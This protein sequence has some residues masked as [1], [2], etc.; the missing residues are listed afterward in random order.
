MIGISATIPLHM[1]LSAVLFDLDGTL[2]DSTRLFCD[3]VI[4]GMSSIGVSHMDMQIFNEWHGNHEHWE[5]LITRHKG[6]PSHWQT[7]ERV[8]FEKFDELLTTGSEWMEGAEMTVRSLAKRGMPMAIVT[9]SLDQFIDTIDR[10]IPLKSLFPIIITASRTQERRK[11]D[12][13]G[14][15]L[16]AEQLGVSPSDCMYVGDQ[17]FDIVAAQGA[18]MH[19]CLF[20]GPHTPPDVEL[21]AKHRVKSL[22][23]I[24]QL[25]D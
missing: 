4:H 24:L 17:R 14:L 10:S 25:I 23:E 12:P 15:L 20:I 11:P 5:Y 1:K 7:L 13:Y 9:N 16:A 6:D 22:P 18:G 19:D 8:T 21:M 3:S 2:T